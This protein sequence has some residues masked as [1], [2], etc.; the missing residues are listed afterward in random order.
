M[1]WYVRTATERERMPVG[2]LT[3]SVKTEQKIAIAPKVQRKMLTELNGYAVI[4]REMKTLKTGKDGHSASVLELAL[5]NVEAEKFELEGF[6][7]A[8]VK[9]AKNRKLNIDKLIKRLVKDGK[10]SVNAANAVLLD[11]TDETSKKTHIRITP[12]GEEESD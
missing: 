1:M 9:D 10:Y 8:V 4:A 12:P 11:C 3:V 7:I 2:N 5:A 6:K